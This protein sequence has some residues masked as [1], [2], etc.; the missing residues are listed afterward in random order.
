MSGQGWSLN[1]TWSSNV[2]GGADAGT[3]LA[4]NLATGASA[5][6]STAYMAYVTCAR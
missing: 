5:A 4:V 3:R 6:E 1:K 2:A